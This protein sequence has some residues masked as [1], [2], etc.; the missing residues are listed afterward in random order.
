M[1]TMEELVHRIRES[2]APEGLAGQQPR[3]PP[4]DFVRKKTRAAL[5]AAPVF[6]NG[7][8]SAEGQA[9]FR[10]VQF[11]TR[12]FLLRRSQSWALVASSTI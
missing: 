6:Y 5:C 9:H 10:A 11:S 12:D 8:A 2:A 4:H 7:S 1:K 3:E